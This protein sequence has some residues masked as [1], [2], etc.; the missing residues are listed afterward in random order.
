MTLF[1]KWTRRGKLFTAMT[2]LSLVFG[3]FFAVIIIDGEAYDRW[4][5]AHHLR[6]VYGAWLRDGSPEPPRADRY[7]LGSASSTTFVYTASHVIDGQPYRGLFG[8]RST[9]R[10]GTYVITRNGEIMVIDDSGRARLLKIHKTK[11]AAW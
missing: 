11:A 3:A 4:R 8:Y 1:S 7:V 5:P 10:L 2:L 9:P 6:M